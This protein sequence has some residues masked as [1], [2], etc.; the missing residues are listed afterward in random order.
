MLTAR[1]AT[2]L[3]RARGALAARAPDARLRAAG[4]GPLFG[5]APGAATLGGALAC[6]LA[7]PRRVKAGAARDHLLGFHARQRPRRDVQGRRQGGEER[8]RLRPAA[9][10]SAGSFGTLAVMTE[11][12]VKVL[13]APETRARAG[14]RP[15]PAARVSGDGRGARLAATRCRARRTCRRR[16]AAR[17]RHRPSRRRGRGRDGAAPGGLRGLGRVRAA[18]GC[19]TLLARVRRRS[20]SCT[21]E[22]QPSAVAR[23]PRRRGVAAEPRGAAA[24]ADLGRAR[25]GP[26]SPTPSPACGET[27]LRLGRRA[28]LARHAA[29]PMPA[30]RPVRAAVAP[31]GGGGHATLLRA[32]T[33]CAPRCRSSS[34]R[35][36][37]RR[38]ARRG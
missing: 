19:A 2:P 33:R 38:A 11:V 1:P 37:A 9:S 27:L 12:T 31:S 35:R 25:R 21:R 24:V 10:C 14:A 30:R 3:A 17:S 32:P 13:P 26:A 28:G 4:F 18:R 15:E 34:R 5:A 6:N 36:P 22:A 29:R 16:L 20:T 8:H 23:G 7:G